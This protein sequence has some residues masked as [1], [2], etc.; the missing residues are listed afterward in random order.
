MIPMFSLALFLLLFPTWVTHARSVTHHFQNGFTL[1]LTEDRGSNV[2]GMSM[3]VYGGTQFESLAERGTFR[4]VL[5][6][7]QRGTASRS[8]DRIALERALL[9]DAFEVRTLAD[10]WALEATVPPEKVAS[11]VDLVHDLVFNPLFP[12]DGLSK[13]RN[14]AVQ[15]IRTEED[16]PL[17]AMVD[18]YRSVFYPDLYA[19][20]DRR[21]ENLNAFTRDDLLRVYREFF[22]P[23]NMV[24]AL[25][26]NLN[27]EEALRLVSSSFGS[28]EAAGFGRGR[29]V[30]RASSGDLPDFEERR[31]G[32]TQAGILVGTRLE[33][34]DRRDTP[35]IELVNA[36][37]DNSLGG[38]LYDAVREREGLVY[39]ISPYFSV[40]IEPFTW[41]VLATTRKRNISRVLKKTELVLKGLAADLPSAQE[42]QLAKNYL[43]TRLAIS[44]S[45]PVNRARYEA[46]RTLRGEDHG[47]LPERMAEID[48]VSRDDISRF[49][50]RYVPDHWTTLVL[51]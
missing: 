38:R 35:V 33:S 2:V 1:V 14:I 15:T 12:E 46:E 3:L 16:S 17:H 13:A 47:D 29:N 21:I 28:Q 48:A 50:E 43:K 49:I 41:F 5:D 31:G 36:V 23:G 45:S 7:M 32:I 40:R 6:T 27:T 22:V 34:F 4:L 26:G 37:L 42:M 8:G 19:A 30:I 25:A 18:F 51:R 24:M 11:L 9:G 10:Y 20:P 39:S 44:Y